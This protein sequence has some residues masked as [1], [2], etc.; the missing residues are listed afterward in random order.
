MTLVKIPAGSFLMGS[1]ETELG[2]APDEMQQEKTIDQP[3]YILTTEVTQGQWEAVMGDN[4][5]YFVDC[6][7]DC[8]VENVSHDEVTG[9]IDRLNELDPSSG[10]YSLPSERQWE[11]AARAGTETPF[12]RDGVDEQNQFCEEDSVLNGLMWYCYNSGNKTHPVRQRNKNPWAL[13]DMHGNVNEWVIPETPG[14]YSEFQLDNPELLTY[15]FMIRGGSW[16]SFA[17]ECRAAAK[18]FRWQGYKAPDIG[19]RL[20]YEPAD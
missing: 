7:D 12:Y 16:R 17:H 11:Y 10:T 20:I 3:F 8:P 14:F 15:S 2:R 13:Y 1:Q 4:P 18:N 9:F 5:S 6:G 19:F